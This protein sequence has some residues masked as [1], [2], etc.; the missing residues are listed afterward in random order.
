MI[1]FI[2]VLVALSS[3]CQLLCRYFSYFQV[4]FF[5]VFTLSTTHS[6]N[7]PSE[8]RQNQTPSQNLQ[9]RRSDDRLV[10][11]VSLTLL[12]LNFEYL[13]PI[14][15]LFI[16]FY[17]SEFCIAVNI[18]FKMMSRAVEPRKS[19]LKSVEIML[20]Q[21]Y[22]DFEQ[23]C[24]CWLYKVHAGKSLLKVSKIMPAFALALFF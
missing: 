18:S 19:C 11:L 10:S 6:C 4:R 20:E 5:F 14:Y 16:T 1:T 15:N 23:G 3:K 9:W 12:H 21:W 22:T 13:L 8:N 2:R 7:K 24:S 17:D